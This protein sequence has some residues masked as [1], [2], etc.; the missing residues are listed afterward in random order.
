MSPVKKA[1]NEERRRANGQNGGEKGESGTIFPAVI[2]IRF[3]LSFFS[4]SVILFL[5]HHVLQM[6]PPKG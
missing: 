1:E 5:C 3:G 4:F 2:V 6:R